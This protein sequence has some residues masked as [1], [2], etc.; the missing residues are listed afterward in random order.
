[1]GLFFGAITWRGDTCGWKGRS[2]LEVLQGPSKKWTNDVGDVLKRTRQ[3]I[4][5]NIGTASFHPRLITVTQSINMLSIKNWTGCSCASEV[6][7]GL[8]RFC[9]DDSGAGSKDGCDNEQMA[10]KEMAFVND[11]PALST[12]EDTEQSGAS[13]KEA[14]IHHPHDHNPQS[15]AA[16]SISPPSLYNYL[17]LWVVDLAGLCQ[18]ATAPQHRQ[19]LSLSTLQTH[20]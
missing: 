9:G 16:V 8:E 6:H 15:T 17:A 12:S 5:Q 19:F 2:R 10:D 20:L 3:W 4:R 13:M 18:L 14:A 11:A 7:H 1:M